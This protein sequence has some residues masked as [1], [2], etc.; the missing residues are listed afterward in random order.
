MCLPCSSLDKSFQRDGRVSTHIWEILFYLV[1]SSPLLSLPSLSGTPDTDVR[2]HR[3]L[4]AFVFSFIFSF[5]F[6]WFYI[7]ESTNSSVHFLNFG[8]FLCSRI[9]SYFLIATFSKQL[10]SAFHMWDLLKYL[11]RG[12]IPKLSYT[13]NYFESVFLLFFVL[14]FQLQFFLNNLVLFKIKTKILNTV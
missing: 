12:F 6:F 4:L 5:F 11:W 9:L 13:L 2:P 1:I 8:N 3:F 14:L 7:L 10:V